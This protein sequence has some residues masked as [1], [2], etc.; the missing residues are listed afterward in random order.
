[1][2]TSREP[3][4]EAHATAAAP[5][6]SV[7]DGS[8]VEAAARD[9][10]YALPAQPLNNFGRVLTVLVPVA[11]AP[12][13]GGW[14][15]ILRAKA[16]GAGGSRMCRAHSLAA[17]PR[18]ELAA[19]GERRSVMPAARDGCNVLALETFHDSGVADVG[20]LRSNN[21]EEEKGGGGAGA[22]RLQRS[23]TQLPKVPSTKRV[24]LTGLQQHRRVLIAARHRL[25]IGAEE[26]HDESRLILRLLVAVAELPQH[27]LAPRVQLRALLFRHGDGLGGSARIGFGLWELLL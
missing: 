26:G 11:E 2:H 10:A 13:P 14:R 24:H 17:A 1:V 22:A 18:V 20:R 21:E 27:A 6:T 7:C 5:R 3:A 4:G 9:E 25:D 12:V 23:Q 19:V 15:V 16:S 8:R